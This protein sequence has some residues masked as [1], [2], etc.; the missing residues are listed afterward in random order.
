MGYATSDVINSNQMYGRISYRF[1][2]L[3][4]NAERAML[5]P[6]RLSVGHMGG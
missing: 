3:Q 5:S 1:S 6:V 4:H 2:A